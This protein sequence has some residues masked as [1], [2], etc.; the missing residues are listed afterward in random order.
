MKPLSA[1]GIAAALAALAA[2]SSSH[3][4][5]IK[6]GEGS[7]TVTTSA[8][9]KDVTVQ[10]S[11]G[12]TSIGSH[13]DAGKLGAPIYPGAEG[14]QQS[15]ISS[16]NAG[17]ATLIAAFK[18]ADSFDQVYGYY[19]Q[20]LPPGSERMKV[21]GGNG[22][23]ATFQVGNAKSADEVSVQVSS[24]KPNETDILITHVTHKT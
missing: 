19:R 2:C 10:T 16:S 13:V 9:R 7:A 17:T 18:T 20:Q 11:E 5:T 14:N 24:D 21:A 8:D 22:S 23:V 15:S 6:T 1:I 12:T 4:T 3:K